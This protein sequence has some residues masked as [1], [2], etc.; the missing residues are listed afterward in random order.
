MSLK[1]RAKQFF[2]IISRGHL[3]AQ[4]EWFTGDYSSWEEASR[5]CTGYDAPA[6]LEKV[7]T[8]LL[9]VKNGK[10]VYERD[11]V[12]FEKIQYSL[13]L[14]TALLYAASIS[15]N[16]LNILDL[17][18]SL[19]STYFQNRKFFTGLKSLQW[20]I[21]EQPHF[22]ACGKRYFADN[23]LQF[24]DS[25]AEC[26]QSR[27]PDTILLSSVL[28]YLPAPYV[29]LEEVIKMR[30]HTII[31]DRTPFF[32]ENRPDRLMIEHVPPEIYV[33]NYPAW[34]FNISKFTK[35][36]QSEYDLLETFPANDT[37]RLKDLEIEYLAMI[38][39]RKKNA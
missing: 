35:F 8:A 26:V 39:V 5:A 14:L 38:F 29:A 7:K 18:G 12:L 16:N 27:A 11:S 23:I 15:G 30:C 2:N 33:A 36:M 10:A 25:I 21:V 31:L 1:Q 17:G 37:Q 24:Y 20:S 3:S 19:G 6:I 28:P 13:P 22:T 4:H 34:F 32:K 9:Q